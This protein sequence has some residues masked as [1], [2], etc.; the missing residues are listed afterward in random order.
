MLQIEGP[1]VETIIDV[2]LLPT[3]LYY[4]KAEKATQGVPFR[5]N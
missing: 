4:L 3:G 5:K 1:T 2:S